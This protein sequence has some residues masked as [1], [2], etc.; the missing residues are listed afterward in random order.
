[1][2]ENTNFGVV[3]SLDLPLGDGANVVTLGNLAFISDESFGVFPA[4]DTVGEILLNK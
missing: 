1:M 3:G 2:S 4:F